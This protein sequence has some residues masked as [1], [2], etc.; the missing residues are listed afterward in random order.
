MQKKERSASALNVVPSMG[1]AR[2]K[3]WTN[4]PKISENA[5]QESCSDT[6]EL[7]DSDDQHTD[8]SIEAYK[9]EKSDDL[10]L[11]MHQFFQGLSRLKRSRD[12][13]LLDDQDSETVRTSYF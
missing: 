8:D 5:S 2:E 9:P 6:D 11:T 4:K 7:N 3:R 1:K 13:K 10:Q 12:S